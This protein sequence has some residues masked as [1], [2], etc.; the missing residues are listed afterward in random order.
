M[1]TPQTKSRLATVYRSHVCIGFVMARRNGEVE[2]FDAD[3]HSLGMFAHPD[4]AAAAI[5]SHQEK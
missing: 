5:Y 3:Q 1:T 4:A 2:A